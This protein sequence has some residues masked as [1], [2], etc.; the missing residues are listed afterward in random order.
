MDRKLRRGFAARYRAAGL[1]AVVF[2]ALALYA[3][4]AVGFDRV[5]AAAAGELVVSEVA[6]GTF[7]EY[8]PLTGT[9][10]PRRTVYLDAVDGGQVAAVLVEEGVM[11]VAGQPLVELKNTNLHLQVIAAEAQLAEQLNF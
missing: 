9:I 5:S 8:I 4:F 11:V 1:G 10:V 3:Y 6:F 7:H 2:A